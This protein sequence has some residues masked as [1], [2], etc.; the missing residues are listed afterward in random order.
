MRVGA[1]LDPMTAAHRLPRAEYPSDPPFHP[2]VSYPEYQWG[3]L[4]LTNLIYEGVRELLRL[5]ELDQNH[6]GTKMWNPLGEIIQPGDRVVLK[7]NLLSHSHR[8]R[9]NEWEQVI[10]HGSV[11]RAVLDYVLLA[12]DGRGEVWIVDGPQ[13]DADWGKTVQRTGIGAVCEFF[14]GISGVPVRLLDLRDAWMDVRGDVMYA[15][16]SLKGDP[17]GAVIVDLGGRSRLAG[18]PGAGRYY[19]SEYDRAETNFHHA[20]GR[21]EYRFSR[22]VA[23]ADVFINLPKMKTHKKVGVTLC[24]KN[25]VGINTGRNWL[26]HHTCGDPTGGG[27]QFPEASAKTTLER[28]GIRQFQRLTL[29]NPTL[30]APLFRAAKRVARPILGETE[31]TV[32]SGNWYGNDTAWRMVHDINRCL[33]YSDG[34]RFPASIPKRYFAVVD[35]VVAGE[36]NGPAAPDRCEAGALVAGFNPVAVDCVA[37]RLMGFDPVKLAMLREA[38]SPADLPMAAFQLRDITIR[39][40]CAEWQGRIGDLTEGVTYHFGAHFGWRGR[41]EMGIT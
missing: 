11:V 17:E 16:V 3:S 10:T 26:P 18:H 9:P 15:K 37:T 14:E 13:L 40:D 21:H 33:L 29:L 24:L 5:L 39:S 34:D 8:Y 1:I 25:L 36:G 31:E 38:F 4:G 30:F 28:W 27:D 32:R 7:P 20:E 41:M 23:S 22:T 35:G 6:Y 12:L 2:A 19:G